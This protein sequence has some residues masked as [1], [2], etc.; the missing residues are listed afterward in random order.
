MLQ[1]LLRWGLFL[2]WEYWATRPPPMPAPP[3]LEIGHVLLV[4]L[5]VALRLRDTVLVN[6]IAERAERELTDRE[7]SRIFGR[8][9]AFGATEAELQWL[10]TADL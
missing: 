6:Q 9:K 8:L 1:A 2:V 4:A 3:V 5:R 7:M 10:S